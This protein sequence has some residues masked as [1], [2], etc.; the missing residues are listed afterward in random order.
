MLTK[1]LALSMA[2]HE[3]LIKDQ[4]YDSPD[5][6]SFAS[7]GLGGGSVRDWLDMMG[8]KCPTRILVGLPTTTPYPD[9]LNS[10]I[11]ELSSRPKTTVKVISDCHLKLSVFTFGKGHKA[12]IGGRNLGYSGWLDVS[13]L[14][15]G[16]VA[17]TLFRHFNQCWNMGILAETYL[18]PV[19]RTKTPNAAKEGT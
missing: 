17:S 6:A 16:T 7:Y 8:L 10:K 11:E 5:Q 12:I 9:V 2:M 15:T 13:G 1:H 18:A 4:L 14:V 3:Y 19:K